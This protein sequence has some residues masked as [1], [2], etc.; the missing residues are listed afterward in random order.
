MGD[1]MKRILLSL[2]F[3]MAV[4]ALTGCDSLWEHESEKGVE[5]SFTIPQEWIDSFAEESEPVQAV[6]S[7]S[8][9]S[10]LLSSKVDTSIIAT[11]S[12]H[13]A[14]TGIILA[15]QTVNL[16]ENLDKNIRFQPLYIVGKTV[17]AQVELTQYGHISR[18]QKSD[19][20]TVIDGTNR[21]TFRMGEAVLNITKMRADF[22][23]A[24][25]IL[26]VRPDPD[27]TD[28]KEVIQSVDVA[29]MRLV[30]KV[31]I[32]PP[33]D[34]LKIIPK[35][36]LSYLF[37][38]YQALLTIEGLEHIETVYV[39][40]MQGV[41]FERDKL[42]G[43][44]NISGWDTSNVTNMN[45]MFWECNVLDGLDISDWDT[46]NVTDM[47][48]MFGRSSA[49]TSL[50]VS[51]WDT[52]RVTDMRSMFDDVSALTSLDVSSWDTSSV[53]NMSNMFRFA[54]KLT[55]LNIAGWDTSS[56]TDMSSMFHG[57]SALVRIEGL[58]NL[59]T[60]SVTTMD[61]MFNGTIGLTE[62]N[63]S[64]WDTSKVKYME[65]MF[66]LMSA[67]TSLDIASWDTSSVVDGEASMFET[68]TLESVTVGSNLTADVSN[69]ILPKS[70]APYAVAPGA[71]VRDSYEG[72]NI[73]L[74]GAGTYAVAGT[75]I[76][77]R[78]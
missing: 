70:G 64:A 23:A 14:E 17:Y 68:V 30:T 2:L 77:K 7:V 29:I 18:S 51:S 34:G 73:E 1:K 31:V 53:T 9:G 8:G 25:G 3:V 16:G 75:Y 19:P 15:E 65:S 46:S 54:S 35:E 74:N 52:S 44:L 13:D 38:S 4:F 12:I 26:T 48:S 66:S 43:N 60:S 71:W 57:M 37:D 76:A 22:D 42:N 28:F 47:S 5:I 20:L 50:D 27:G 45:Q 39:T 21:V 49:L 58:N 61:S 10:R 62:L 56:V 67:L 55:S 69:Q 11:A 36:D 24:S 33:A 40:N 59:N 41:F 78:N 6:R 32:E 72:A 63:L